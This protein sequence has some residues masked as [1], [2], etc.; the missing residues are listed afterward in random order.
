MTDPMYNIKSHTFYKK[1]YAIFYG[2]IAEILSKKDLKLTVA[3]TGLPISK[4]GAFTSSPDCKHK[5]IV[6][7]DSMSD[8]DLLR[9]LIDESLH[10]CDWT[11]DNDIVDHFASDIANFLWRCG[12][13]RIK[14]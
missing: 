6:I 2:K 11:I 13:R 9:V 8:K 3:E 14:E 4:L 7:D 1:K 10:A 12:Y 5:A